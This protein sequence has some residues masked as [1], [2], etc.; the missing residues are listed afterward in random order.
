MSPSSP[1]RVAIVGVGKVGRG[2]YA[3]LRAARVRATIVGSR[4][5]LESPRKLRG[6]VIVIAARD[7]AIPV[8]A[9]HLAKHGL[10]A[11]DAI[12]VHCAGALDAEALAALRP[13]CAGVAQMHPMISF[14]DPRRPPSL[15]G[16]HAHVAGDAEA[17]R[18]AR[19]L[20]R[21]IGLTPRTFPGLDRVAYH[22]AAGLVANGAAA[23]AAAGRD[24]L[25]QAG[26]REG[27]IPAMLGPLLRSV[28]ENV[29]RMGLPAALTGPVRRGDA[30]A[31]G[32]HLAALR[33]KAP[34]LVELYVAAGMAQLPLARALGDAPIASFDAVESALRG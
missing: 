29:E 22:A 4:A 1:L 26:A 27:D 5:L 10:V 34:H 19:T 28:A 18:R 20:C 25:L 33:E 32:K 16:G 13:C 2:L 31:V 12:V 24:L 3:A 14:A 11:R 21:A 9:A 30:A 17:V 8:V 15:T 7:G 23:L 6:R